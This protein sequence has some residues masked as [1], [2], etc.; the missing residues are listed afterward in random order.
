[1]RRRQAGIAHLNKKQEHNF[2]LFQIEKLQ[3]YGNS[4][5]ATEAKELKDAEEAFKRNL[6]VFSW[7]YK[8]QIKNDPKLRS[9]FQKL[10][11]HIGVDPLASNKGFWADM[12]GVGDFYYELGIQI[13]DSCMRTRPRDGGLTNIDDLRK[14]VEDLRKKEQKAHQPIVDDDIIRAIKMLRPL[15]G[16]FEVITLGNRKMIKSVPDELD[17]DQGDLLLL[18][19]KTGYVDY[20]LIKDKLQWDD[21]RIENGLERLLQIGLVWVDDQTESRAYWVPGYFNMEN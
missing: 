16:G 8:K 19:Q 4:L 20:T 18:A 1:M 6:E 17:K 14:S 21:S 2:Y 12:L 10:C 11:A 15:S 3:E 7:K 13:I 9:N 5:S